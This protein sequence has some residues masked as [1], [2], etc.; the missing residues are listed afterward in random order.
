[1]KLRLGEGEVVDSECSPHPRES[2]EQYS[3]KLRDED[4]K[5]KKEQEEQL[6][7]Y[8]GLPQRRP[9]VIE[10]LKK[11]CFSFIETEMEDELDFIID[12]VEMEIEEVITVAGATTEVG[13]LKGGLRGRGKQRGRG[14][15]RGGRGRGAPRVRSRIP[16]GMPQTNLLK[17]R[18]VTYGNVTN[19][20]N[21][22]ASVF[23]PLTGLGGVTAL[24]GVAIDNTVGLN[25]FTSSYD[26]YRVI[27]VDLQVNLNNNEAN[28][29]IMFGVLTN[30]IPTNNLAINFQAAQGRHGRTKFVTE[31]NT[32][33]AA[34]FRFRMHCDC[35]SMFG[36]PRTYLSDDNTAGNCNATTGPPPVP[37]APANN[38]YLVF[39]GTLPKAAAV[40]TA[41]GINYEII[42]TQVVRFYEVR[43]QTG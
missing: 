8:E 40:Y 16:L 21:A 39:G 15:R 4:R 25:A 5:A 26:L 32:L 28:T 19:V 11:E 42:V 12:E 27:S 9:T 3:R 37:T 7:V 13:I 43:T 38:I 41:A 18:V 33:S 24:G 35:P 14:G 2:F 20:G 10:M 36:N 34:W 1:M 22:T 29:N 17:T 30:Q 31:H 6:E 23:L